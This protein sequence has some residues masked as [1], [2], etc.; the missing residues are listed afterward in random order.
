MNDVKRIQE[1]IDR[2]IPLGNRSSMCHSFI[3]P[4]E[5]CSRCKDAIE[6]RELVAKLAKD[7][8]ANPE[9]R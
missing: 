8:H 2:F 6:I 4:M 7:S 3:V 9:N 5:D 1:I